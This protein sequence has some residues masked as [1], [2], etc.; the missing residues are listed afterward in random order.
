LHEGEKEEKKTT[1]RR[2]KDLFYRKNCL[3]VAIQH[4]PTIASH[5]MNFCLNPAW[6][7]LPP[8]RKKGSNGMVA[9]RQESLLKEDMYLREAVQERR[10]ECDTGPD[11]A[12]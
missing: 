5:P 10:A 9:K 2:R 4:Q 1:A 7:I 12:K 3:L 11:S 8:L 6:D